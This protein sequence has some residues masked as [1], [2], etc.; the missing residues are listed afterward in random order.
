MPNEGYIITKNKDGTRHQRNWRQFFGEVDKGSAK[1]SFCYPKRKQDLEEEISKMERNLE[2]GNVGE[3][4][5][6][7]YKLKVDKKRERLTK[8]NESEENSKKLFNQDKD[9]W[10]ERRNKLKEEISSG[11]PT[12]ADVKKRHVNPHKIARMEKEGFGVKKQEYIVLSRLAEED[13]NVSFLQKD[14]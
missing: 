11:L 12:R 13:S 10:I 14:S 7:S 1:P 8:I 5:R 3:E 9:A 2:I 4:N 6:M